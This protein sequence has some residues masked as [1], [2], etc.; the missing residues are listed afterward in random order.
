M[1]RKILGEIA[2][3][4]SLTV[5]T[6]LA[7]IYTLDNRAAEMQLFYF[8][9][10]ECPNCKAVKLFV[11]SLLPELE[12]KRIVFAEIDVTKNDN[13][14]YRMLAEKIAEKIG[15][16]FIPIPTAVVRYE[17]RFHTF[18][19]KEEVLA[20]SDFFRLRA[21]TKALAAKLKE[22]PFDKETC[23]S[24]H[25]S[26]NIPLPSTFNCTFCCHRG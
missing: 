7:I 25:K 19:G 9:S 21:G 1:K 15:T 11:E 22:E 8:Y 20:L 4:L 24:C 12:K 14:I 23:I 3:F 10:P 16:N 5:F 13:P 18:I 17:G 6:M 26:R 2:V